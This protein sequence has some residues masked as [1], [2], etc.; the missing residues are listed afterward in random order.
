M[1]PLCRT[2]GRSAVAAAPHPAAEH[3]TNARDGLSHDYTA[4]QGVDHSEIILPPGVVADWAQD[5]SMLWNAA[6]AAEK[7]SDARTARE[8]VLA[9]PHELDD[10]QRL[11]LTRGFAAHLAERYGAAVDVAIHQPHEDKDLR[12]R[13]AHLLMT[14]RQ[15]T[16][17]GLGEKTALEWKNQRLQA[18]GLPTSHDQL[19]DIRQAWEDHANLALVRAGHE[20]QIDH[21]SHRERGLEIEPTQHVGVHAT[22]VVRKGKAVER[23]R[24]APPAAARNAARII[25]RPEEVLTIITDG[26]SVL[27]RRGVGP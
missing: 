21:R 5:R 24:I 15:V 14:T 25:A 4:R 22:G 6:E 19:R 3:L 11:D 8:F 20:V 17:G 23:Q 10:G 27:H 13:H 9:L 18:A 1:K 12:N 7:R 2:Q 16:P 26:K